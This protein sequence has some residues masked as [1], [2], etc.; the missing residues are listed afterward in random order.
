MSSEAVWDKLAKAKTPKA[1]RVLRKKLPKWHEGAK[2]VL[3]LEAGKSSQQAKSFLSELHT[4]KKG[5][6]VR[7]TRK[8][9]QIKPM[10][11]GGEVPLE[12]L[13]QKNECGMFAVAS[14]TK[15]RPHNVVLGRMFDYHTYDQIE[16]GVDSLKTMHEFGSVGTLAAQGS[17][18]CLV[19]QGEAFDSQPEYIALKSILTDMLRGEVV[20]NVALKGLDRVIC[21]AEC[22][23][24]V[25]VRQCAIRFKKSG[26]KVPRVELEEMGPSAKLTVRR[27]RPAD[28]SLAKEALRMAPSAKKKNIKTDVFG[29]KY[30]RVYMPRQEVEEMALRKPKGVKR[31]RREKA[32]EKAEANKTDDQKTVREDDPRQT[33]KANK[34]DTRHDT[35]E[36]AESIMPGRKKLKAKMANQ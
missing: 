1:R 18:P 30:G 36:P 4:L 23:G 17:K 16:I 5:E 24:K 33:K 27:H 19:F 31:E 11:A 7:F 20:E 25:Y 6:S 13:C 10:E 12:F 28:P 8:N 26:T 22:E 34:H 15:K 21:V 35:H 3:L 9:E 32:E 2:K 14:H 29:E